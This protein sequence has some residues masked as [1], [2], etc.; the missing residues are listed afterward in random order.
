MS[1]IKVVV[2]ID[3]DENSRIDLGVAEDLLVN[4]LSVESDDS[5]DG[6]LIYQNIPGLNKTS[7]II[8]GNGKIL[9]REFISD[10]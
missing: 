2:E 8:L 9:S 10:K 5:V 7:D 1:K 4:S 3:V 6:V